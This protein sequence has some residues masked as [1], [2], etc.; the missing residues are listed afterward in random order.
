MGRKAKDPHTRGLTKR[1]NKDGSIRYYYWVDRTKPP[2]FLGHDEIKAKQEAAD[3]NAEAAKQGY[4]ELTIKNKPIFKDAI[5]KY[6]AIELPRKKEKT[7]KEY[8]LILSRLE[9]AYG[10]MKFES[11]SPYH[12]KKHMDLRANAPVM[13]NREK[14]LISTIWNNA[15]GWGMTNLPN[16]C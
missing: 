15:R 6:I 4:E 7:Q 16:P 14:A 13:A 12:I 11:I 5:K 3:L 2:I 8:K 1:K 10:N 9:I